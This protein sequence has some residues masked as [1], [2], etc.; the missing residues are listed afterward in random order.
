M[1]QFQDI[2]TAAL[3]FDVWQRARVGHCCAFVWI[4][5]REAMP[6]Q[7]GADLRSIF[8][9]ISFNEEDKVLARVSRAFWLSHATNQINIC[10]GETKALLLGSFHDRIWTVFDNRLKCMPRR[11]SGFTLPMPGQQ[12]FY[13]DRLLNITVSLVCADTGETI[14]RLEVEIRDTGEE[15]MKATLR[16]NT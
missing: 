3:Q 1:F 13:F 12:S 2:L 11:L 4:T 7:I 9:T 10:I 15:Q 14:K 16:Q 8:A 5:N 6:G